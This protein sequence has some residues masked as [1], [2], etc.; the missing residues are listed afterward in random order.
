M[1]GG[2][3]ADADAKRI[4]ITRE[5]ADFVG[6]TVVNLQESAPDLQPG[7]KIWIPRKPPTGGILPT[8]LSILRDVIL[9]YSTYRVITR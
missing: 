6:T 9:L 4:Q 1:A 3:T 7:D 8:T 5:T 2:L